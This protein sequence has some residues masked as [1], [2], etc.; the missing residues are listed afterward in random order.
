MINS[1]PQNDLQFIFLADIAEDGWLVVGA[2]FPE[3]SR[4]PT[5]MYH[6]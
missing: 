4:E 1:D 2:N 6:Y 5:V 3:M